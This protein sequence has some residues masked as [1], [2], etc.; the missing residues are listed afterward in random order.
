MP[1]LRRRGWSSCPPRAER[2]GTRQGP[3]YFPKHRSQSPGGLH[4]TVSMKTG[5]ALVLMVTG[6]LTEHG[7]RVLVVSVCRQHV[8]VVDHS[9]DGRLRVGVENRQVG[10]FRQLKDAHLGAVGDV[11][12]AALCIRRDCTK[13]RQLVAENTSLR[14]DCGV[15]VQGWRL[16]CRLTCVGLRVDD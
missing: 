7:E 5:L 6:E 1:G 3:C 15:P 16:C 9:E 8:A 12:G 10:I 4:G 11:D 13:R 14:Y 2:L